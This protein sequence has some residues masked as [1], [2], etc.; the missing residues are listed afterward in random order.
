M[1]GGKL[2]A[3]QK[4]TKRAALREAWGNAKA[5]MLGEEKALAEKPLNPPT[6]VTL[7]KRSWVSFFSIL[8]AVGLGGLEPSADENAPR[9]VRSGLLVKFANRYGFRL[10]TRF[11]SANVPHRQYTPSERRRSDTVLAMVFW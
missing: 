10:N 4:L 5:Q 2:P 7:L 6:P 9:E 8:F 1:Y 3:E 11:A